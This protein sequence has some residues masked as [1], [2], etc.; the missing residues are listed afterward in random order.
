MDWKRGGEEV[1]QI[2]QNGGE[3]CTAP[4][5]SGS[6]VHPARPIRRIRGCTDMG[7]RKWRGSRGQW[8]F[9]KVELSAAPRTV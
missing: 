8:L 4:S 9:G 7:P 2:E 1:V 6:D 3:H 5:Q